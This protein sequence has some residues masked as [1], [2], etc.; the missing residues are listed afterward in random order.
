MIFDYIGLAVTL[1]VGFVFSSIGAGLLF[2]DR[3]F[4]KNGRRI[5]GKVKAIEKYEST[6]MS[7]GHR[8]TSMFYRPIV[9]YT[10]QGQIRIVRGAGSGEI[11][12][13]LNQKVPVLILDDPESDQFKARIA[14]DSLVIGFVFLIAGLGVICVHSL[15]GG[16][17]ILVLVTFVAAVF[18][19]RAFSSMAGNFKKGLF[20]SEDNQVT[21]PDSVL[22]E[23]KADYE[24]EISAHNF[25]G[26]LIAYAL[27][28]ASFGVM[29]AGFNTL[30]EKASELLLSDFGQFWNQATSGK[31]PSSWEK[32]L[33]IF[34]MG[35]FFF[36]ASLRSVY[37][38]STKYGGSNRV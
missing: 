33:M 3:F 14:N 26:K 31:M 13:K 7:N 29:Y 12:S 17:W 32:G 18:A 4:K 34:G 28:L 16:S 38:V 25:W 19:G 35:F 20:S 37:Y 2:S 24:A 8:Q 15:M 36:L 1:L 6:T 10:Y 23:T 30:P 5:N 22:I 9:E 11:G 27:M 21:S